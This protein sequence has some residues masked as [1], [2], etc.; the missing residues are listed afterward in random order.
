[1]RLEDYITNVPDFPEKGIQFKDITPLLN[2][3]EA[4]HFTIDELAKYGKSL[5]ATKVMGP[6][7]RGFIFG[8]PVAYS[9]GVGFVPVRKPG[10]LPR[11]TI[12]VSYTLEY[13][14][15]TLSIHADAL[16]KGDKVYIIDD[17]MATGGTVVA[18]IELCHKLGAE[19]V[20]VG[21]VIELVDLKGRELL[22]NY[23][24]LSLIKY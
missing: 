9:L 5:G 8:C 12:D 22:G 6:D 16:K 21:V 13:G 17:L 15:N 18:A 2:N 7:A 20:G 10:K 3:A 19:V 11:K 4:F 14:S 24:L 1:M 23:P